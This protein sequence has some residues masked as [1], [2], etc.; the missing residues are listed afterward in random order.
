MEKAIHIET[1][2]Q[3]NEVLGE[4]TLHPLVSIIDLS[5]TNSKQCLPLELGFIPFF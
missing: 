3:C 2:C 5:K 4:A 1:V